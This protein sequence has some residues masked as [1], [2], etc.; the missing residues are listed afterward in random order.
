VVVRAKAAVLARADR[1]NLA[2]DAKVAAKQRVD[3]ARARAVAGRV[4]VRAAAVVRGAEVDKRS[5][6]RGVRDCGLTINN[7]QSVRN[8]QSNPQCAIQSSIYNPIPNPQ[9]ALQSSVVSLQSSVVVR[10]D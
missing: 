4:P 1:E 9:S 6:E 7:Q 8:P 10:L 2:E 3:P 5:A